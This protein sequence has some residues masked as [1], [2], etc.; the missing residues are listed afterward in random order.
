VSSYDAWK[1]SDP[2]PDPW[3]ED[4]EGCTL[5]HGTGYVETKGRKPRRCPDCNPVKPTEKVLR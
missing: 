4:K 2:D 1:A 5:C 3:L